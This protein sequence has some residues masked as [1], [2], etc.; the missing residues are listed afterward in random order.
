M[1]FIT[2]IH[3]L[4]FREQAVAPAPGFIN[5]AEERKRTSNLDRWNFFDFALDLLS[6]DRMSQSFRF[7]LRMNFLDQPNFFLDQR[8][9]LTATEIRDYCIRMFG[10]EF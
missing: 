7:N 1:S 4:T 9:F 3:S 6:T 8:P 5:A 2:S 10:R